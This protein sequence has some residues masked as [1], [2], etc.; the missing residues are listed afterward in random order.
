MNVR[1]VVFS[2]IVTAMVGTGLGVA[3][4]RITGNRF[5]SQAY[6]NLD[7]KFAIVG[8]GLGLIVGGSQEAVRQLKRQRDL[9]E[10]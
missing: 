9:E 7:T 1:L 10:A 6:Q 4:A 8:A 5:V 3:T 2:A